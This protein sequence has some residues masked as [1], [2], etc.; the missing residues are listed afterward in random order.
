MKGVAIK[1]S[2]LLALI[3]F[4][5]WMFDVFFGGNVYLRGEGLILG[6]PAVVAAEYN[7]TVRDV[8]VKEGDRVAAGQVV[9]QIAS[10]QI[11]EARARLSSEAAARAARLADMDV[12]RE[13]VAATLAAAEHREAVALESKNQLDESYKKGLLPALTRTTA[14]EQAY[15]G[16]KDA[17]ALRAEKRALTEQMKMLTVAAEQADLALS[18]LL[19]L[20]DQGRLH[21]PIAGTV[22][23]V[24]AHRGAVVRAGD[25]LLEFVGDHRFVIAWVPVGRWYKLDVGQPVSIDAGAGALPGTIARIGTVASALPREFQKA[26]TPTE[27]LQLVWIEF[28]QGIIPPPYFTKVRIY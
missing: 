21:A 11:A 23:T 3:A 25:A 2:Y 1:W 16:Q 17:E 27:R 8:L 22:S 6:Q 5:V 24:L 26:F 19:D 9:V 13:V 15:Q 20:Y 28:K 12:R 7:V 10:Q 18:D 14:A 4:G